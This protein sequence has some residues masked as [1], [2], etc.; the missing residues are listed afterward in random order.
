[1]LVELAVVS[2]PHAGRTFR[3]TEHAAFLVG[4]S[5]QAHFPLPDKDPHVSR[6]HLLVEVNPPLV[7]AKNMSA[8]NGTL[9]NGAKIDTADLKHG[10]RLGLGMTELLVRIVNEEQPTLALPGYPSDQPT[11]TA[12]DAGTVPLPTL[13]TRSPNIPGYRIVGILGKGGMGVVYRAVHEDSGDG[14]AIK[15]I[16]PRAVVPSPVLVRFVREIEILKQ[17]THPNIVRFRES[18]TADGCAWLAMELVAGTDA[19]DAAAAGPLP[20]G[21]AVGWV[22][23]TLDALA[24]AH[25]SGF[26][27]RDVK[28]QNLLVEARPDGDVVKLAD[29]GLARVYEASRLSGVTLTNAAG[30]TPQFMPPEQ[31]RDMRSVLPPADQYAAA[32][33]LYRLLAG[34][35]IYPKTDDVGELFSRILTTEPDPLA[36]H[37]PDLPAELVAAVHRAL[38]REP[39][40]RFADCRTFAN[41]LRP[42]VD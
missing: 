34:N 5:S 42:F 30:G 23:Q 33:T 11:Q 28:P 27:H 14:V 18:G 32:A 37:R 35:H 6:M 3:F 29:F 2:G 39:E 26:V 24:H 41:A 13:D 19:Q 31:V 12:A 22:V 25:I 8:T 7:R 40:Q 4:R 15:T 9:V 17:L 38:N 10:D 1:M 36:G 20:T 16:L 21:R